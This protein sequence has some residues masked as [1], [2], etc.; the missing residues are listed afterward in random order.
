MGVENQFWLHRPYW[1][2]LT[3]RE[4]MTMTLVIL[5][6]RLRHEWT[7]TEMTSA[8]RMASSNFARYYNRGRALLAVDPI[9]ERAFTK[10][11][12]HQAVEFLIVNWYVNFQVMFDEE[13]VAAE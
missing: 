3:R 1:Q 13:G 4:M 9:I 7:R 10:L 2:K 11:E 6:L 8:L 12:G 5:R